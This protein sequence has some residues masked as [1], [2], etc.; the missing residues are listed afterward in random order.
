MANLP[1]VGPLLARLLRRRKAFTFPG[2]ESY[3]QQRYVGGRDSGAGSHGELAAFKAQFLNAFVEAQ[4]IQRVIEFG[5]GDGNQLSLAAYP[6]YHGFDVSAEALRLCRE[7]FGEDSARRFSSMESYAGERAELTLSLD[8]VY[9]L[10]EDAVFETFMQRLFDAATRFVIVYSSD[11]DDNKGN[12][13][14][15]VRHR[16]FTDWVAKHRPDWSLIHREPN[17]H[18]H[19]PGIGGSFADFHVFAAP[20]DATVNGVA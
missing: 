3:W 4:H 14:A 18:P 2:S 19:Q 16:R 6:D 7:R 9:H 20:G 8:V 13:V 1:I 15:H 11:T 5:C 17:R 10:V 12:R